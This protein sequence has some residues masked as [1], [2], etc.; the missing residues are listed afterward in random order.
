[1]P[2]LCHAHTF[3]LH[4]PL[5][6]PYSPDFC[7]R[8]TFCAFVDITQSFL[9]LSFMRYHSYFCLTLLTRSYSTHSIFLPMRS[10]SISFY[11]SLQL[12]ADTQGCYFGVAS[13]DRPLHSSVLALFPALA[14]CAYGSSLAFRLTKS[15]IHACVVRNVSRL[16]PIE[17][18]PLFLHT[19]RLSLLP[20]S[21]SLE[22]ASESRE[23]PSLTSGLTQVCPTLTWFHSQHSRHPVPVPLP[24]S[25]GHPPDSTTTFSRHRTP[26]AACLRSHD[27]T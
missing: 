11:V 10:F 2:R 22:S 8:Y 9:A 17:H 14:H 12:P 23:S 19:V 1:M 18:C 26:S 7:Q 25:V 3:A 21:L 16:D 6:P 20:S 4:C 15:A 5:S 13:F 24:Q 27:A